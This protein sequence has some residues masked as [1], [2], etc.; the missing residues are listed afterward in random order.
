MTGKS[1]FKTMPEFTTRF[2]PRLLTAVASLAIVGALFSSAAEELPD[3]IQFN[4]DVRPFM[5]NT[6]FKCH[7]ADT[8]SN[9]A[10]L[11]LDLSEF[12]YD[13][14]PK[15][16]GAT[17]TPIVP[18]NPDASEAW[19]RI[20]STDPDEVM[21]PPD[22]LHQLSDR[23][24]A[25]FKKWIEQGAIY[26]DHWAYIPIEK[27][28]VPETKV[29]DWGREPIDAF[30]QAKLEAEGIEPSPS[31]SKETLIRRLSLDL[32][33]LPPTSEEVRDFIADNRPDAYERLIDRLLESPRYGERMAVPWLDIVRFADTVGYHGD[34]RQNI[35]PYRDYVIDSFNENKPFDEFT[36]EQI[37]GD[38]LDE[39]SEAQL[40]ATGFNRLN[41]M[42]REGGAQPK[43]YLA[44]YAADRVRAV[45]TAWLG[46]TMGC[47]EC[48]DHK[49]DP[50]TMKD[51]YSMA[52]YF[53][54]I[55]QYGV[56][57]DYRYTPEPDLKG[58]N[59]D[60]PFPPEIEVE[61][62]YLK[63]RQAQLEHR[64]A[65]TLVEM[66]ANTQV[67]ANWIRETS[68]FLK[69]NP[70][71][72]S[73]NSPIK[74]SSNSPATK[75]ESLDDG[76]IRMQSVKATTEEKPKVES[77]TVELNSP[78]VSIA[79]LRIEV[80]PDPE[81]GGLTKRGDGVRFEFSVDWSILR[82]GKSEP[83]KI[84]IS[85][86]YTN[87]TGENYF[88]GYIVPNHASYFKSSRAHI[89]KAHEFLFQPEQSLRLN[90]GDALIAT[91]NSKTLT[92]IRLSHSPFG[93]LKPGASI[94]A[95]IIEAFNTEYQSI[96]PSSLMKA[97]F[98]ESGAADKESYRKLQDLY[99]EIAACRDGKAFTTIT[100]STEPLVTRVLNRGDWQD[101]SGEIVSP[102][103]PDFLKKP[104]S[105]SNQTR[106]DLAHWL[107][108]DENPLTARAFVNRLWA[109]FFGTGLS[110]A[111]DDLGNQ[112]E[113]P[114]HP[115]LLDY[116]AADF[117]DSGWDVKAMVKLIA[118][119]SAYRQNS[120][121]RADVVER[122]PD[123]RLLARQNPRRLEAEF[124]RD[125]ALFVAGLLDQEIGGPSAKPYQPS[126]YY[127]PLNFP[128][129]KYQSESDERQFRR[130]VYTHWQRSF[131]HPMMA[132]FDAP[133]RE[134]CAAQ[135]TVSNTP[136][137]ALTL[138]NDPTFVEAAR[139]T[140]HRLIDDY[141]QADFETRLQE[142]FFKALARAPSSRE[143]D[144]LSSFFQGRLVHYRENADDALAL[145]SIGLSQ[146]S[147]SLDRAELAAWTALARV[148]LNLN[149]TIVRY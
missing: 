95:S 55:K 133:G 109:Q 112:G 78:P 22:N 69:R 140:A 122:D 94:D 96:N 44:K 106:L 27:P 57:S 137:Q 145:T 20:A 131:L 124:V 43:E 6:C 67:D 49:Y 59:N 142:L 41:L 58:W 74:A 2:A 80:L 63:R 32:I 33:G 149:E 14:R 36:I 148:V 91:I 50:F 17:V 87:L 89:S 92:R 9:E 81:Q 46:S 84:A 35:F 134:E 77:L 113:W 38:L 7:G 53:A 37:A 52:A 101:E 83:E 128:I 114:S 99:R 31:A 126:G 26:E 3:T 29:S 23:E 97:A 118:N 119:S 70:N 100:V 129:R 127:A 76:S 102:S 34:Q 18:G 5:S 141:P 40:I 98:V 1:N 68:A 86:A 15:K 139:A 12:A 8:K 45:S 24:K 107:V 39:P 147:D 130:G 72:W 25:I 110:Y 105:S 117:R 47:A 146:S 116:L 19:R 88:N 135:R 104:G 121:A 103:E 79:S 136:Q 65:T 42:T 111:L 28:A 11:R 144:S 10:D 61:S 132:N 85:D 21:P 138:L 64:Y 4:R 73:K 62:P 13:T 54:D 16:S 123:N 125:N 115:E 30:I 82:N 90:K 143:H 93:L 66:A 75:V 60:F 48:H 51:F 108:S 120:R 71:G 56:Y